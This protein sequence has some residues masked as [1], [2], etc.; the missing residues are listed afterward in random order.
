[1]WFYKSN[2][3]KLYILWFFFLKVKVYRNCIG[4]GIW[5]FILE[6]NLIWF[7]YCVC[8][9]INFGIIV[10]FKFIEVCNILFDY[11]LDI[12]WLVRWNYYKIDVLLI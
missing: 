6:L 4:N 11:I 10:V 8:V 1:M 5:F 9:I 12:G 2:I 3:K 7:D